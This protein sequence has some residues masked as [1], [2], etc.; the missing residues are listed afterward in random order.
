MHRARVLAF[1]A[2]RPLVLFLVTLAVMLPAS[3]AIL[4]WHVRGRAEWSAPDFGAGNVPEIRVRNGSPE[5]TERVQLAVAQLRLPELP[6]LDITVGIR[7]DECTPC[8]ASYDP[9]THEI[10]LAPAMLADPPS[11]RS[12]LAHE[13]G[14]LVDNRLLDAASRRRFSRMRGHPSSASWLAQDR[15]WHE[16]PSEDFAE[17]FCALA[18]PVPYRPVATAYGR[19]DAVALERL[20]SERGFPLEPVRTPDSPVDALAREATYIGDALAYA[21]ARITALGV[22]VALAA[23]GL[24]RAAHTLQHPG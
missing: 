24:L 12:A 5:D 14:H 6:P 13:I 20:L 4:T 10:S 18:Q 8:V 11:L 19:V 22:A 15:P 17:A 3:R 16:R 1:G 9:A 2:A 23:Q 21:W 7:A